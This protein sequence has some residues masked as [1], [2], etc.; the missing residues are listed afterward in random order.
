M[1]RKIAFFFNEGVQTSGMDDD[2]DDNNDIKG[3]RKCDDKV[4]L[5]SIISH[6][7]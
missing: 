6:I 5:R 1:R 7:Y 4:S 3:K 2:D